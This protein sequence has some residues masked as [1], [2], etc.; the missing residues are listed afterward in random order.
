MVFQL[1]QTIYQKK[2][3]LPKDDLYYEK[4]MNSDQLT[5][6]YP[7]LYTLLKD[8][9]HLDK[10][11]LFFQ[12]FLKEG[13]TQTLFKNIFIK[14]QAEEIFRAFEQE[15]IEAI[16][17]KG[18]CFSERYFGHIGARPTSD[19]D[20]LVNVSEI[21]KAIA[22]VKELGFVLE[23]ENL[24]GHFHC[25]FSK[26]LLGSPI[27]LCVEIHW[28]VIKGKTSNFD[29]AEFWEEATLMEGY[30]YVYELSFYHTFYM[31]CLHAWRHNLDSIKSYVDLMQL[32]F[33]SDESID[34]TR[35][36]QDAKGHQTWTRVVRTLS[37]L[38]QDFPFMRKIRCFP[39]ERQNRYFISRNTN[40]VL[41]YL[42]FVDYHLLSYDNSKH[43][44]IGLYTGV[45]ELIPANK[46]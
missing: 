12:G 3:V 24:P 18:V 11:P 4:M 28:D 41:K 10:T 25:S 30:E 20:L 9:G 27:P 14:H 36:K 2:T 32:L 37:I 31:M 1:L 6:I 16:P 34:F 33:V 35:L 44:V 13:Y 46:K 40:G 5:C 29:I 15:G 38:Y 45:K 22:C 42:N 8:R 26:E 17:L 43:R 21:H 23:D 7:Q 19:I 39:Y